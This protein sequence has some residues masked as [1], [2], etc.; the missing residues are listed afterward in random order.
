MER[1]F[2]EVNVDLLYYSYFKGQSGLGELT[3][4]IPEPN[5]I[6]LKLRLMGLARV[7]FGETKKEG[8]DSRIKREG[9]E[10]VCVFGSVLHKHFPKVVK[11]EIIT[12]TYRLL[13]KPLISKKTVIE[14]RKNPND[15]D[16]MVITKQ[17]I[18]EAKK[19]YSFIEESNNKFTTARYEYP[20][21]TTEEAWRDWYDGYDSRITINVMDLVKAGS[22]SI[23]LH[24]FYRSVEQFL[25]GIL[26]G[27][28]IS[29]SVFE[30]GV[31]IVGVERF[32]EIV[33]EVDGFERHPLHKAE[34][35]KDAEDYLEG[36]I[37]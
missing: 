14:P 31:P 37:V 28:Y 3:M 15:F 1:I 29:K 18:S 6:L 9:I 11:K 35:Y 25:S 23:G 8:I 36:R 30:Y 26:I 16:L 17:G 20:H 12:E 13:R 33:S 5:N 7:L 24:V 21:K 19:I 22:K 27:D 4:D 10:S 2:S 34:F 32:D